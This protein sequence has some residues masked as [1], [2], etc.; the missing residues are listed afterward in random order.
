MRDLP[1]VV[2]PILIATS[3]AVA[4]GAAL[5]VP[6]VGVPAVLALSTALG[7][8]LILC[9]LRGLRVAAAGRARDVG[10]LTQAI[11]VGATYELARASAVVSRAGHH[12]DRAM[13]QQG[14][15]MPMR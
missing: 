2:V 10:T 11:A 5:A 3:A 4:F 12:R 15:G 9:G 13:Y 14:A 8:I 6:F 7:A 1:S